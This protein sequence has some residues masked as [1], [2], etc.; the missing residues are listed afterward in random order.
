MLRRVFD[1]WQGAEA[2]ALQARISGVRKV[3]QS[4]QMIPL[5]KGIIGHY[6]GDPGWSAV[7]PPFVGMAAGEVAAVVQVLEAEHGFRMDGLD[8]D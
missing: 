6:R 5:L 8:D 1:Q 3:L 4:A 7:R 2:D